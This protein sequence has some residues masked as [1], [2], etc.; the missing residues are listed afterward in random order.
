V[1]LVEAQRLL[2]RKICADC[3]QPIATPKAS[4]T[5]GRPTS[6][7]EHRP[8]CTGAGCSVCNGTGYKGRVALYEVMTFSDR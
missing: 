2:R 7:I 3:K 5:L 1:N 6:K 8:L 4:S